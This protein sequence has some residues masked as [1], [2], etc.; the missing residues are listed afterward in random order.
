MS[1]LVFIWAMCAGSCLAL[2]WS[3]LLLAGFGVERR[4]INL[5]VA[6]MA[7]AAGMVA[8]SELGTM[9]V[10]D[11]G[12]ALTAITRQELALTALVI[13]IP[14]FVMLR[15]R[16]GRLWLAVSSTVLW[17][18]ALIAGLI[19]PGSMTFSE[20]TGVEMRTTPWGES[21]SQIMGSRSSFT[22]LSEIACLVIIIHVI[23]ASIQF[24]RLGNRRRAWMI[25]GGI[26]TFFV[27]ALAHVPMVDLG[28][29]KTPYM[30]G[31]A[32]MAVVIVMSI[33]L[34]IDAAARVGTE[35][36]LCAAR[37]RLA[38]ASRLSTLGELGGALAHELNQPLAAILSNAQAARRYLQEDD[39][40]LPMVRDIVEDL[41][42]DDKRASEI[43]R[44]VR[45][46]MAP[47][48]VTTE[49]FD[50]H[51][52]IRET[53]ALYAPDFGSEKVE[54]VLQ[55]RA[56]RPILNAGR[57]EFQQVLLNLSSN[58]LRA[59]NGSD[60]RIM[61]IETGDIDG[62]LEMRVRD[63]G[64]GIPDDILPI[65]FEPFTTTHI[66]GLGMGLAISRRLLRLHD[67]AI[68]AHNL[69]GG[70]AEFIIRIPRHERSPSD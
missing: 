38:Q 47:G 58:A 23:D 14:W 9:N 51:E 37:A 69:P 3:H 65:V 50:L 63:T 59:M 17:C 26:V 67:S 1:W 19:Q 52:L 5:L 34:V 16:T 54:L 44:R 25:G 57:V 15:F 10:A 68:S 53:A 35:R 46:L 66:E 56:T 32:F 21:F 6:W 36:D 45:T 42:R 20:V 27:L 70:G 40:D 11:T 64:S 7:V 60:R 28:V 18:G 41:I 43:V 29:L 4:R 12:E 31:I 55:L 22:P 49:Q 2:A 13:P 33:E 62:S 48:P 24:G 30:V 61:T 39:P 8:L